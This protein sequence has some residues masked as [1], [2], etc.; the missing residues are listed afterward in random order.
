VYI[1]EAPDVKLATIVKERVRIILGIGY[2]GSHEALHIANGLGYRVREAD[3]GTDSYL[4][5]R[6]QVRRLD[7]WPHE[8]T[9]AT[10]SSA[11]TAPTFTGLDGREYRLRDILSGA[12]RPENALTPTP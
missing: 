11:D 9:L 3:M 12:A 2:T 4:R 8:I 1:I 10:A 7:E 6:E 5:Y